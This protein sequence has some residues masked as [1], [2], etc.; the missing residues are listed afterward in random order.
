MMPLESHR[1]GGS[2]AV[3][4]VVLGGAALVLGGGGSPSPLTEMALQCVAALAVALWIVLAPAGEPLPQV[5][6]RAWAIA[7]LVCLLPA[8]Q[9]IPL[10]PFLWH[11]LPGR[12]LEV[13]ALALVGAEN[14]WM[15]F[16][17]TPGRTLAALLALL[18]AAAM[19]VLTASL[20]RSGRATLV[21]VIASVS[22]IALVIGAGQL[23]GGEGN[24]FRF[25]VP[26]VGFLN[27][28]Q[29]NHNSAADVL[30]IGMLA[31]AATVRDWGTRPKA[32]RQ[33]SRLPDGY[34]L[35][36]VAGGSLL[37]ALGVFFTASRMGMLLFPIAAAG[38]AV[39]V[40]PWLRFERRWLQFG[41]IALVCLTGL[42]AMLL[43]KNGA[44]DRVLARFDFAG[45]FR[46]QLWRD[47]MYAVRQYFPLGAGIGGFVPAFL[48]AERLE[49]VDATM[50]NRAH[51]DFMEL[52]LE[53]GLPGTLVLA[54]IS[55]ILARLAL[56]AWRKPPA[57]SRGQVVFAVTTLAVIAL[58]SLTDYPLRSMSLAFVAAICAGLLM[59]VP[60]G[61]EPKSDHD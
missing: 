53:A 51:N 39:M 52:L 14:R 32:S 18:P 34:R 50:P 25:Y 24:A 35:A 20:P 61:E 55:M 36:L 2:Q 28:F 4:A 42:A 59:P 56:A 1:P 30:M 21:A 3:I 46:P 27:G 8:V 16:S 17:M 33:P 49:V 29:A 60:G 58:H 12:D 31:M 26:D 10:P 38:V 9:L 41:A 54:A 22:L 45:E 7:G 57:G 11:L 19:L 48:A 5:D 47:T 40:W 43:W 37:F 6:R 44:V 15:P 13:Q 23:G